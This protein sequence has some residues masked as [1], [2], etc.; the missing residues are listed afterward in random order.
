MYKY[1]CFIYSN[2]NKGMFHFI[3]F[4]TEFVHSIILEGWTYWY[5]EHGPLKNRYLY[6]EWYHCKT[7]LNK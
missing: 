2:V 5:V 6:S 1:D 7:S 3:K 4:Y